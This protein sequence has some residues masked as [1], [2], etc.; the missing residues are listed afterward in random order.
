MTATQPLQPQMSSVVAEQF[1]VNSC[2]NERKLER[3]KCAQCDGFMARLALGNG[4]LEGQ[5]LEMS[6]VVAWCHTEQVTEAWH[7]WC[8]QGTQTNAEG[9]TSTCIYIYIHGFTFAR[10]CF[11]PEFTT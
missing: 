7:H 9:H 11:P 8:Q 4:A 1:T 2:T 5:A 3:L 10:N 6:T